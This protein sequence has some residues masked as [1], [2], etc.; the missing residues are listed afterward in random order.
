[1]TLTLH[2]HP[3]ARIIRVLPSRCSQGASDCP[4]TMTFPACDYGHAWFR[5]RLPGQRIE[6]DVLAVFS[7]PP[8]SAGSQPSRMTLPDSGLLSAP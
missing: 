2:N 8:G 1:M 5:F 7:T 3:T 4:V 6:G